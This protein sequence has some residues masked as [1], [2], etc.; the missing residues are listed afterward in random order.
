MF[1]LKRMTKSPDIMLPGTKGHRTDAGVRICDVLTRKNMPAVFPEKQ[2][3]P[4]FL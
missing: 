2:R 3:R 4:A 1:H